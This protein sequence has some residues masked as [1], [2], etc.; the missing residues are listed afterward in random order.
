MAGQRTLTV[1]GLTFST[2]GWASPSGYTLWLDSM[3]GWDDGTSVR[4][5]RTPRTWGH[6]EFSERGWRG[7]RLVTIEGEATSPTVEIATLAAQDLASVL[8]DGLAGALEVTDTATVD[9]SA[10]AFLFDAPKVTWTNDTTPKF[11]IQ[12]ICPNSRKF[13]APVSAVTSVASAGGALEYPLDDVLD[14]GT[15]GDPGTLTLSNPGTADTAPVFTITGSMPAGFTITH[16]QSGRK[17][18][19]SAPVLAGQTIRIDTADGSVWL[20]GSSDRSSK[21]TV[22][23]WTRLAK[24]STGTWLFESVGSAGAQLTVEVRPAWW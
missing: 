4:R 2:E 8:G 10:G 16:V 13:G 1:D 6:G 23:A 20:D 17:L 11:Q 9:M 18:V 7:A 12:F 15:S 14:Y 22:R 19:Y 24:K 3:E 21:L 5:D